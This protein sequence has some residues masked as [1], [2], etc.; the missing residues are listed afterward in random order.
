MLICSYETITTPSY[1]III[2]R[3]IYVL[4]ITII[5]Y[6]RYA[7]SKGFKPLSILAVVNVAVALDAATDSLD[8]E[9]I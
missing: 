5:L 9:Y 1:H 7:I 2:L 4:P 6:Y 8:L 3:Y